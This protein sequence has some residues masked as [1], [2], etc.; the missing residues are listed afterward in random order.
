MDMEEQY[1]KIYRY[2]YF[3]L[4]HRET[5]EDITQETFLRYF[6]NYDYTAGEHV[7]KCL[8]TIAGNLCVDEYRRQTMAPLEESMWK[9][10]ISQEDQLLTSITVRAALSKLK[11]EEQ[12]LLLLRYVN[13]VS[14]SVI[15][16]IL[17]IS[18]FAAYHRILSA[19]KKFKEVFSDETIL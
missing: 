1:D 18:R 14:V 19:A 4:H 11:A 10:E 15:G 8:Y 3:K 12:E 9:E 17:G 5:A 2:C 7:I 6:E 13:E 16:R